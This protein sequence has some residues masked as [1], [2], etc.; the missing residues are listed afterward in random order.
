MTYQCVCF[1]SI[2]ALRK[3]IDKD[4]RLQGSLDELR[5]KNGTHD[6]LCSDCRKGPWNTLSKNIYWTKGVS[7]DE[8][9][10]SL[11]E[12]FKVHDSLLKSLS[13]YT[14]EELPN[15]V[16]HNKNILKGLNMILYQNYIVGL[17][18]EKEKIMN[19][20]KGFKTSLKKDAIMIQSVQK[21]LDTSYS[22]LSK[23]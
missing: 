18:E 14:D 13:Q 5:C 23:G 16:E 2:K 22:K 8:F 19:L 20:F 17:M 9:L 7:P 12:N 11:H 4:F 1:S 3:H 21:E 15:V 6:G 10:K